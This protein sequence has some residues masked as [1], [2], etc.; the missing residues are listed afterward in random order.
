MNRIIATLLIIAVL[1]AS[2]VGNAW[3]HP[4]C[5][6]HRNRNGNITVVQGPC[7]YEDFPAGCKV[8]A[9]IVQ[10]QTVPCK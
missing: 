4:S 5:K 1:F 9:V 6:L 2:I 10:G 3:A 8:P 7:Y